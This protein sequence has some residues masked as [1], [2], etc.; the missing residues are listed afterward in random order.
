MAHKTLINGTAYDIKKGKVLV[1]GTSY[2]VKKGKTLIG[3]TTYE[4]KMAG[5]DPSKTTYTEQEFI[6]AINK[7]YGGLF[8]VG[9]L[10]SLSNT[11]CGTYEVIGT[12]HDGTSNTVDLL[13]HTQVHKMKWGSS[14]SWSASEIRTWVNGTFLNAF[15]STIKGMARSMYF[16]TEGSGYTT[17]KVRLLSGKEIGASGDIIPSSDGTRYPAFTHGSGT[18]GFTDA[19]R[20]AGTRGNASY[21]WLRSKRKD[22]SSSILLLGSGGNISNAQGNDGTFGVLPVLRF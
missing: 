8:Q 16:Y 17:D 11:Y 1:D 15:S 18:F 5:F 9:T 10:I 4:I 20:S 22:T 3:G 13:A 7:G 21:L 12:N 2:D 19:W 6:D 14:Q